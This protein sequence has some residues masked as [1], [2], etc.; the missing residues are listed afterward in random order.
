MDD[1][2]VGPEGASVRC[3]VC[4][5][6]FR[7]AAPDGVVP[8]PWQVRT[9]DDLLFTAPDLATLHTWILEGRLHPD[10]Q[11]SRSGRHFVRL[12]EMPEFADAFSGFVG[13][14]GVLEAEERGRSE[15]SALDVL[16]PP[17]AFGTHAGDDADAALAGVPESANLEHSAVLG[18]PVAGGV[19][20]QV[21][22]G[23]SSIDLGSVGAP[24]GRPPSAPS[25]AA[26][27][28]PPLPRHPTPVP[29]SRPP[30]R[31][32]T[33]PP[34]VRE[35]GRGVPVA[36]ADDRSA[37][38]TSMLDV[39]THHVRPIA[40]PIVETARQADSAPIHTGREAAHE[41]PR[42]VVPA[43]PLREP[44]VVAARRSGWAL[45]AGLGLLAGGAVVFGIPQI[46][47]RLFGAPPVVAVAAEDHGP[48]LQ[49]AAAALA[50]ADPQALA[51]ADAA[52]HVAIDRGGDDTVRLRAVAAEVLATRAVVHELW[53]AV[54]PAMRGDARFWAQEDAGRAAALLEGLDAEPG[55]HEPASHGAITR[56]MALLR[57]VHGRA[58]VS[59][60]QLDEESALLVAAAPLLRDP[61]AK[62]PEPVRGALA[63]LASPSVLARLVLAL[64]HARAGD[65]AASRA[66]VERVLAAAPGQPVARV[67]ARASST[68]P[69]A[70]L[71]TGDDP[72]VVAEVTPPGQPSTT[73]AP[74]GESAERLVDRGCKKAEA[75]ASEE[76]V[77][78]L[79]KALEK[80]P[81]D[82]DALLCMGDAQAKLGAYDVAL[83]HYERALARS[84]Q[85]MSALQ[86]AGKA[87]AKLGRTAKAVAFYERLLEQDPSHSQARAY[88]D[89]HPAGGSAETGDNG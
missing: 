51:H 43:T 77:A 27:P 34:A 14:P 19:V 24:S 63:A 4:G 20:E 6:V 30:T 32:P 2:Q 48:V 36:V 9:I 72:V 73:P 68:A 84:P 47:G 86:G 8:Q 58:D 1:R 50:S 66:V 76:A 75:G 40:A 5:E 85:M 16:G 3:S 87:A 54:E 61:S 55:A 11:V 67:L 49:E 65:A 29:T 7:V 39:V 70:E 79:R 53:A 10:D 69:T 41:V 33:L 25:A 38:G 60:L 13:L 83:K 52:L 17:P 18:A 57:I 64:G 12:G 42:D 15:Q 23:S 35:P 71:P 26:P 37:R 78:L 62:L 56:A 22:G 59:G 89:A 45:W 28:R 46:R 74:A 44:P 31:P 82:L 88:I 81:N 21:S 80:R